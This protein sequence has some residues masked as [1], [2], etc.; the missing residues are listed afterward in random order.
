[1]SFSLR[2]FVVVLVLVAA[3][4]WISIGNIRD[5]LAPGMR[6]SLEE[7]LVDTSNLL[8]VVVR[9][10]LVEGQLADGAF[11]R[12][13]EEFA[14]R[15]LN[16]VIY[17]LRKEE[18][19][20]V[21]YVTDR[22][23]IVVY[24]SRGQDV[25]EDYSR[26]NDVH[27]TL[28]GEYGA[29]SSR[30]NPR[31]ASTSV[32]YVAAPIEHEGEIVGV[33]SVG[34]PS[35]VVLPFVDAARRSLWTKSAWLL[36]VAFVLAAALS[37]GL[38]A[39]VRK[40]TRYADR[41]RADERPAPPK[42]REPEL[43]RLAAA[44]TSMRTELEGKHHVEQYLH[45]LTHELKSPLAAIAG[46]AELLEE[47]MP[48]ESRRRFV[49]NIRS[50]S[51]RLHEV[52]E[53]LLQLSALEGRDRLEELESCR[54]DRIVEQSCED[55]RAAAQARGIELRLDLQ[56]VEARAE[57]FLIGQAAGNLLDNAIAF[58]PEGEPIE[59]A[60]RAADARWELTVRDRGPGIPD[61]ARDRLFERFYSLPRP[62]GE[63]KSSGLGLTAVREVAHLHR[64]S[65]RVENHDDGGAVARLS[66]PI[67]PD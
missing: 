59:V 13:F 31:D 40:L 65:I 29:R 11:A 24:D 2:L 47:D 6:Q 14:A 28:R 53:R 58:S 60:L 15:R 26:W 41:V 66:L 17:E 23:G 1:M 56:A 4:L 39:S 33:L 34:K 67:R 44:M 32:M 48:A 46:A 27:R 42:I 16:A 43:A 61:Y 50:Q 10:E 57:P 25:G 18:P 49:D 51:T 36:A 30:T 21:V 3:A 37:F 12:E 7:V 64:G 5:E 52:V 19:S 54:V 20:L 63:P 62:S 55:R 8:A 22:E 45:A 38:T 35:H 9:D